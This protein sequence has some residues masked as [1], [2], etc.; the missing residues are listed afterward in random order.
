MVD[1]LL[2]LRNRLLGK[3]IFEEEL[4]G[5]DR[6]KYG[7]EIIAKLS[8]YLNT[9]YGRGFSTRNLWED[10]RFYKAYPQIVQTGNAQFDSADDGEIVRT[11]SAQ[12]STD[13]DSEILRTTCAEFKSL[14][15]SHYR[16]LIQVPDKTARDWYEQEAEREMWSVKTLQRNIS[17]QY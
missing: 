16:I 7:A 1:R 2:I 14:S 12:F 8:G 17:T 6:A 4:K 11:T 13:S 5:K 9:K 3:R 15:W 10:L